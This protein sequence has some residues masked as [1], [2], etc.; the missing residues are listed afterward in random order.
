MNALDDN[1][2]Q[3][4][5]DYSTAVILLMI[6][7]IQES[8]AGSPAQSPRQSLDC[9][10]R[11]SL[12]HRLIDKVFTQGHIR[13]LQALALFALFNQ[14]SGH[15][16]TLTTMSGI[17]VRLAQSLGLHRHARRFKMGVGEIELRKRLWWWVYVFDRYTSILHGIPPLI[18]DVDVD[19]DLPIDCHLQDLEAAELSHPLP[20]ERTSVFVFL[21]YVSLGKKSSQ[22]L[23]LLYTTTQR[24][25]GAR[26]ITE[27]ERDLRV[28]NQNLKANGIV[29][30]IGD[31]GLQHLDGNACQSY[32]NATLWL[33]LMSNMIMNLIHRPGL[34]FDDTSPEFVMCLKACLD[35]G[36]AISSLVQTLQIPR[37]LRNLSLIGPSTIFQSS[38]VHIYSHLKFGM[39]K[40]NGLPS[41]DASMSQV[42]K[43]ISL[44]TADVQSSLINQTAEDFYRQS[45]N[46]IIETLQTL[47][48]SLPMVTQSFLSTELLTNEGASTSDTFDEQW[49]GNALDALNY[50][51]ASDWMGNTSNSA[52]Q[53]CHFLFNGISL[54]PRIFAQQPALFLFI[55]KLVYAANSTIPPFPPSTDS[56]KMAQKFWNLRGEMLSLVQI[57]T[58]V[59]PAYTL[60]GYNQ[61]GLG[62]LVSLSDWVKHF[63]SI[64][65]VNTDG[66][67]ASHNATVQGVVIAT[68]TLGALPGCL[69]CSYTADRFGR[70]PVIFL[71]GLLALI[72]Q[73]LEASSY[74]L[75]QMIVGRTLLGAGIGMLSGTVPTWQS[76]C[77]SSKNR[78]KHI[79][80][81]GLFIALGYMLQAWINF[82]FY[83][84]KTGPVTWRAPIAIPI[85][86]AIILLVSIVY[87]PESP[88]WL[89][90][91]HRVVEARTALA[92]LRDLSHDAPAISGEISSIESSLE[93]TA[94]SAASLRDLLK[95]GEDRLLYR[96]SICI[97]LQFFQQMSGGNLISVYSSVIFE[98]GLGLDAET[99][100]ILSGGTLTWKFLS[101]FVSFFTIDRFGRR[102]ALTVSGAGMASCMLGLA[103]ATSFPH[104]NY[105]AQIISVLFVFLFNFFIPIGFLGANFLYCTEVAP[106]RL[107]V[108]MS[109]ISTA[110][111]WLWNFVVTMITPVA[112][113]TIGYKYYI[114]YTCIGAFIPFTVYFLYPETMGRSLEEIDLIFRES[115]SVWATVRFAK[116]RP[117]DP[118]SDLPH[119]VQ[120]KYEV[121][122]E[123]YSTKSSI[124]GE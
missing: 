69:S 22:I 88:R 86:F 70:R 72:G 111:H 45:L 121:E 55:R 94:Q 15:C 82:G 80:L 67:E 73:V 102:L 78:G 16:L 46:E 101:C 34:S 115:P 60:F 118:G 13:S 96:F 4:T 95:M 75:A 83:Q 48:S 10:E 52:S 27:L 31:N 24:R 123:E 71:G 62:S 25:D 85:I 112:I 37:W 104:S 113:K 116:S 120:G 108:A 23:D 107:R 61:S 43:A 7:N 35:S 122:H 59:C 74:Q 92:S 51:T 12:A 90:R 64:D 56:A 41:L 119:G 79:V 40:P 26:K 109:S 50:M 33:Q 99:A 68:F 2:G 100:R 49:G 98:Q 32:D 105:A 87:L 66:V 89:V 42:S 97:L 44:L 77:S 6:L 53:G 93:E 65:T 81:D 117:I 114:V 8:F 21:Q 39:S 58:V 47:L 19:N 106:I 57:L 63:P 110:N 5:L 17:M 38:L 84:F 9:L 3:S 36:T 20:G 11:L 30:D 103:I 124:Q 18:N 54:G 14:L 1:S 28:W 76:E 91:Q 29:F